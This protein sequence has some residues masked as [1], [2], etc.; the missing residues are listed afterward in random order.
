MKQLNKYKPG[1]IVV[2]TNKQ[3]RYDNMT[4]LKQY[5]IIKIDIF[6]EIEDD[7]H[8]IILIIN[9]YNEEHWISLNYFNDIN[10]L[11]R[12]KLKNING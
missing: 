1:D 11:R 8:Y 7:F 6:N 5:I 12:N 2:L 4:Y 3:Y 10:V 9:D